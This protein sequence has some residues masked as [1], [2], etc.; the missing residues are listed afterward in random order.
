MPK[1]HVTYEVITPESA[2]SG[3]TAE[4]GYML[5]GGWHFSAA[6]YDDSGMTLREATKLVYPSVDYGTWFGGN[7]ETDY[8]TAA[9]ETRALHPPRNITPA[10]YR[11]L[12]RLFKV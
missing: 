10:S 2:E 11:R 6:D 7:T 5:P 3:D 9:E 4:S 8:R 1:F 12:R